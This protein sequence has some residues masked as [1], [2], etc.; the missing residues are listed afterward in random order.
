MLSLTF[1]III[2][3]RLEQ[4]RPKVSSLTSFLTWLY[5]LPETLSRLFITPV[6]KML[7]NMM[8]GKTYYSSIFSFPIQSR[9][10]S[11]MSQISW[12]DI[13]LQTL[14]G[15]TYYTINRCNI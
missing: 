4:E 15:D 10:S 11:L 8:N 7:K 14:S 12:K 13:Q 2:E 6:H 5:L 9:V 1:E 3:R